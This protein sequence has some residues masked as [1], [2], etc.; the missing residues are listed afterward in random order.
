MFTLRGVLIPSNLH[1][2]QITQLRPH[3]YMCWAA[4]TLHLMKKDNCDHCSLYIRCI[5]RYKPLHAGRL[6]CDFV[7]AASERRLTGLNHT[8]Q[9]GSSMS[10]SARIGPRAHSL[11][12]VCEP[13]FA[14][15]LMCM[16]FKQSAV[17]RA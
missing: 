7:I 4:C 16:V 9:T 1:T 5:R 8:Y 3:C 14:A 13:I 12:T 2:V 10:S 6:R 17:G 15:H 11:C